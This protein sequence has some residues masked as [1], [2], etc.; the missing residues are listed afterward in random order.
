MAKGYDDTDLQTDTETRTQT[1]IETQITGR[2]KRYALGKLVVLVAGYGWSR[3]IRS[4]CSDRQAVT[5]LRWD[6]HRVLLHPWT[7]AS[8][9]KSDVNDVNDVCLVAMVIGRCFGPVLDSPRVFL[10]DM[11]ITE[12]VDTDECCCCCCWFL[13]LFCVSFARAQSRCWK[14]DPSSRL[15]WS[16]VQTH[17]PFLC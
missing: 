11:R 7:L 13:L 6:R 4:C 5:A 9:G 3:V 2:R 10:M 1:K 14:C 17:F 16:R 8:A 15:T 12:Y